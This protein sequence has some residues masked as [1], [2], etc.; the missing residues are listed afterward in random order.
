[1]AIFIASTKSMSRGKG[2]S[3][4]AS[5]SYRSGEVLED[6]RYGRT[7]NYSKR[8]GVMSTDIIL[9]SALAIAGGTIDRGD[10]WNK[11]ESAEKRRD[12]RVAREWLVNL[13][14]DLSEQDRK[15]LALNFAQTLANRYGT[16]ADC[17]IHQ[18]TQKEIER[19]ADPRNFHAHIMFTTRCAEL[20]D[21]NKIVLTDKATIELSDNKRR[22][23]G[24]E[25]VNVEIKE[26]RQLWEQ[27]ANEKLVEYNHELIDSRS[28]SDQ[29]KDIE[30]Q[31]KMGSVAT[32][33]ERDAY[34]QAKNEALDNEQEFTGIAPV[35]IR[36]QINAVIAERN[37]LVLELP[38]KIERGNSER[39]NRT[40]QIVNENADRVRDTESIIARVSR[41]LGEGSDRVSHTKSIIEKT[42]RIIDK[43]TVRVKNTA[44]ATRST[45]ER[46]DDTK[47][48]AERARTC[49]DSSSKRVNDS[50]SDA[51]RVYNSI[52]ERAKPDPNPFDNTYER[53]FYERKRRINQKI[54]D[55]ARQAIEVEYDTRRIQADTLD[56]KKVLAHRLLTRNHDSKRLRKGRN[57]K[58]ERYPEK[59]D[60]RQIAILDEFAH[61]LGIHT[62]AK[63]HLERHE[64][65]V[66]ML[67]LERM[68]NNLAAIDILIDKQKERSLHQTAT[69]DFCD[70]IAQTNEERAEQV[71]SYQAKLG[72]NDISRV[73]AT[74]MT[75]TP[76]LAAL[77]GYANNSDKTHESRVLAEQHINQTIRLTAKQ[78]E[79]AYKGLSTL[80]SNDSIQKHARALGDSLGQFTA[81]YYEK[82][83]DDDL[84]S[85]NEGLKVIGREIAVSNV[86]D[87]R[88]DLSPNL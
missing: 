43:N 44:S 68:Q 42:Q 88:D 61:S 8:S 33:L 16:I 21:N 73:T 63:D 23:L 11:A 3:A 77:T 56:K 71:Q 15:D 84:R 5:A 6:R 67:S 9:P 29:G 30:P 51:S 57:D 14:H 54:R 83:C 85:I 34:E 80:M 49:I 47:Q 72:R 66:G 81:G 60:Y 74:I 13:P 20:D 19:G 55:A 86:N 40:Q 24:L 87:N 78:Y 75:A 64:L 52:T 70:F 32:K 26:I 18:P 1:M 36:G 22:S 46:I 69:A 4:V 31:I 41:T 53:A 79:V 76:Y 48:R 50:K 2:Q 28:Y 62:I 7:H 10:L 45:S 59:F 38:N 17:A 12:A 25:R 58:S 65:V 35:T 39:I 27:I 82:L 37:R